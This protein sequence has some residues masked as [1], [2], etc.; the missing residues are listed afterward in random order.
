MPAR[1]RVLALA[2]GALL[3]PALA[4]A[5]QNTA[6]STNARVG[7]AAGPRVEA[8][9]TA[10]RKPSQSADSAAALQRSRQ[11]VGKPVAFMIVGG[12]AIVLGSVV[13]NEVGNLIVIGG[14]V[15]LLYG[16]YRYLQ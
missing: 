7:Q 3:S 11:N 2:L 12:A 1:F 9:A 8:T 6:Q 14:V 15:A 4:H 10:L 13:D 16:L 5:Q